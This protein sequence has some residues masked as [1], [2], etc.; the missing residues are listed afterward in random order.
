MKKLSRIKDFLFCENSSGEASLTANGR[1]CFRQEQ[2]PRQNNLQPAVPAF[3]REAPL[4]RQ[5]RL[6]R[7]VPVRGVPFRRRTQSEPPF[8]RARP[9]ALPVHAVGASVLRATGSFYRLCRQRSPRIVR[10]DRNA[11]KGVLPQSGWRFLWCC[12][13]TSCFGFLCGFGLSC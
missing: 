12:L 4:A 6:G 1:K 10:S 13:L 3:R 2:E 8:W 11:H 9:A 7:K 5:C